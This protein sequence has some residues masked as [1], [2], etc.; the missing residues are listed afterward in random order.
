MHVSVYV[1]V[2]VQ[3]IRINPC[4]YEYT[5]HECFTVTQVRSLVGNFGIL[6]N[7]RARAVEFE[8]GIETTTPTPVNLWY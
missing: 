1:T 7:I 4:M 3:Y 8:R 5:R 2:C 6:P